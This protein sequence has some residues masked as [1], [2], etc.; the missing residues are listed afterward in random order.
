MSGNGHLSG[1][2]TYLRN[3]VIGQEEALAR[4]SRAL[5]ASESDL[6]DTGSRPRASF[7][8][9]GASGIGKTSTAKAFNEYLFG[10]DRLTMLFMNEMQA[11]SDV[12]DLVKAI[13]RGV[14]AHPAGTVILFDEI[15]K[16]HK[17]IIDIFISLTDEGQI[18]D[19]DGSRISVSNCYL[20]MTSNI[21][22]ARW[23]SMEQTKYSVMEQFAFDS[24]RK[25]LRPELFNR[26]TEVVVYRPLNHET[27][28]AILSQVLEKKLAYLE[29]KLGKLS[30][31]KNVTSLLLRKCFSQAGGA[32]R[33]RQELDRQLNI[34]ALPWAME[35]R[36]PVEGRF[37]CNLKADCLE[38]R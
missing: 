36:K 38:L 9:M 15:E 27:Q 16:A 10:N 20:V 13:K 22:A 12:P 24:A 19:T 35:R 21:G 34:A 17:A 6:N 1:L 33:L 23:G 5:E 4:V 18:T 2:E 28:V 11:V 31:N 7:L 25:I 8:F 32:R 14:N 3:R 37:Y 30:V 29:P 26:L